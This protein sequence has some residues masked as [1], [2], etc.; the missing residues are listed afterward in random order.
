MKTISCKDMGVDCGYV[1]KGET[2]EEA[3]NKLNAHATKAHPEVVEE[4]SKKM[5]EKEMIDDM[6]SKVKDM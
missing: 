1:A 2:A 6:M 4:M 3:V 5:S